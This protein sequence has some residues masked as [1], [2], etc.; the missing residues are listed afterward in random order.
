MSIGCLVTEERRV[1]GGEGRYGNLFFL[2]QL[3]VQVQMKKIR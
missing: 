1:V 3:I 2:G